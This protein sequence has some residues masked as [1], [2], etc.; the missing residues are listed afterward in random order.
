MFPILVTFFTTLSRK[1]RELRGAL[2]SLTPE[3]LELGAGLRTLFDNP[4]LDV[5]VTLTPTPTDNAALATVR[6][7]LA[8]LFPED[9]VT[10]KADDPTA[11][12]KHA[13]R[14]AKFS[15]DLRD[16]VAAKVASLMLQQRTSA[17]QNEADLLVQLAV[18]ADR[19]GRPIR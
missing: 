5:V 7:A 2:A 12:S 13:A 1:L 3:V 6:A 14:V 15:P 8:R 19:A 17:R 4:A 10:A 16:A 9:A 11:I 18:S